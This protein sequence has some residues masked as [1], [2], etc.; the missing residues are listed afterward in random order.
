VICLVGCADKAQPD[1]AKCVQAEVQ[2]QI[3]EAWEACN[4]AGKAAAAKLGILKP[5][6]DA[7]KQA[8]DAA[9]AKAAEQERQQRQET[10]A[11][12]LKALR[13]KVQHKYLDEE[14]D[15]LCTGKGLPPFRW[16]YEG[17]T[18]AEDA[19]VATA[20]GC[21]S[22]FTLAENTTFCCPKRPVTLGF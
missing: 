3:K 18:F 8:D 12:R 6:Y 15:S 7:W 14:P 5:K 20:D 16:S 11:T 1:Y 19:E 2:Q 22:P 21:Q 4:A 9:Q 13:A 10:Q 17:G